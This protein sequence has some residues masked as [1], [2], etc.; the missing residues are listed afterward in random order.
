MQALWGRSQSQQTSASWQT[1]NKHLRLKWF[2]GC[3]M[4]KHEKW[5]NYYIHIYA[6]RGNLY[7]KMAH[8]NQYFCCLYRTVYN[9]KRSIYKNQYPLSLVNLIFFSFLLIW[10]RA[11]TFSFG[12]SG[13]ETLI[14]LFFKLFLL[15]LVH[16][17]NPIWTS[18]CLGVA[19]QAVVVS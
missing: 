16:P 12:K 14:F 6:R 8:C 4:N 11:K 7:R 9:K 17:P 19:S 5:T 1:H 10:N 18:H 2:S 15:F 3:K 13:W